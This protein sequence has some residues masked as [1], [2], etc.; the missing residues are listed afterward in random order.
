[1]KNNE[2]NTMP[3]IEKGYY[4]HDSKKHNIFNS[5]DVTKLQLVVID[6]KTRIYIANDAD[7]E[8]ARARYL[9][10]LEGKVSFFVRKPIASN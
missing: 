7:P 2:G 1:M 9:N 4:N 10:R 6:E 5:P 3:K 8:L